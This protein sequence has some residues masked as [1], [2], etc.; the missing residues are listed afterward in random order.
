MSTNRSQSAKVLFAIL[1]STVLVF[2]SVVSFAATIIV[3]GKSNI[4]G[5]GHITPPAPGGG[6][7]GI[8]PPSHTFSA[9]SGQVLT[10]S[11]IS[12]SVSYNSGGNWWGP[13]GYGAR[14]NCQSYGGISG[15]NNFRRQALIGL[16]LED[17]ETVDPAPPSLNF[18]DIGL[19]D[20]FDQLYPDINQ[21]F[22][23]GDGLTGTGSG[24]IQI[25][26]VPDTATRIFLGFIDFNDDTFYAYYHDNLGAHTATFDINPVPVPSA[27][28]L[29][30]SG[31]FS[32]VAVKRRF[33]KCQGIGVRT[34]YRTH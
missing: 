20:S 24:H 2:I 5:A 22:F 30:S 11:N 4:Y 10:F 31:L 34:C 6:N 16:F 23:I 18:S 15:I 9:T 14:G 17:T 21:L 7:G 13:D 33:K 28:W 12:G 19:T 25:F 8:L 27:V 1:V 29:L 26:H 3:D 32:V